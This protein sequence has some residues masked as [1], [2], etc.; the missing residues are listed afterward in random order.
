MRGGL[1]VAGNFAALMRRSAREGAQ[2]I[3]PAASASRGR[4]RMPANHDLAANAAD[5]LG[6]DQARKEP[7]VIQPLGGAPR[8]PSGRIFEIRQRSLSWS[9]DCG[10]LPKKAKA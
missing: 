7:D 5:Q 6:F 4:G 10:T 8:V 9:A 3:N 2:M 1:L